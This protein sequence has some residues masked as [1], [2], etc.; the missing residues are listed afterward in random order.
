MVSDD[1]VSVEIA[2]DELERLRGFEEAWHAILRAVG[3]FNPKVLSGPGNGIECTV[4]EIRR[5]HQFLRH[6]SE[7]TYD[8]ELLPDLK[9]ALDGEYLY[10]QLPGWSI[11]KPFD[12][13]K[14]TGRAR[15]P[16]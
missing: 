8:A 6:A 3:E 16:T 7:T 15:V 2:A 9:A 1:R 5:L 12:A 13:P 4:R 14:R 10:Q 11:E